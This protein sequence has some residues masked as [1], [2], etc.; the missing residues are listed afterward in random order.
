MKKEKLQ[1]FAEIVA[2]GVGVLLICNVVFQYR[3]DDCQARIND[4]LMTIIQ[5]E[6]ALTRDQLSQMIAAEWTEL[7]QFIKIS[8]MLGTASTISFT[9]TNTLTDVFDKNSKSGLIKTF[10]DASIA[11]RQTM[12]DLRAAMSKDIVRERRWQ[13]AARSV[14]YAAL[15]L[16]LV[17]ML[18][19][20]RIFARSR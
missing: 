11:S 15:T 19:L 9:P 8:T 18:L 2:G 4:T 14:L 6:S 16:S 20:W 1:A 3:A 13:S 12:Q 7:T 5:R 17:T 10:G